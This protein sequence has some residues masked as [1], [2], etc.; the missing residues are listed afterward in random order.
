MCDGH[1]A[2]LRPRSFWSSSRSCSTNPEFGQMFLC[3]ATALMASTSVMSSWI[4]RHA[5][6]RVEERLKPMA[7]CTSTLPVQV[8]TTWTSYHQIQQTVC[9]L[10]TSRGAHG[11]LDKLCRRVEERT[12]VKRAHIK[13]LHTVICDVC[14]SVITDPSVNIKLPVSCVQH[15]CDFKRL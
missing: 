1:S 3:S 9:F 12:E 4:I 2:E 10:L 15:V 13:R 11:T 5:N 14:V 8:K 6:T 7:Q